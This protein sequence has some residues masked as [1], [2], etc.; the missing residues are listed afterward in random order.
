M[1]EVVGSNSEEC[2]ARVEEREILHKQLKLLAKKS[3]DYYRAD[4]IAMLSEQMVNIYLALNAGASHPQQMINASV[5]IGHEKLRASGI[6][7]EKR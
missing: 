6:T 4:S 5:N 7:W 2:N 3:R 1:K